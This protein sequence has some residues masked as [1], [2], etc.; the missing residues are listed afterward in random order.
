MTKCY[1]DICR[2]LLIQRMRKCL[3]DQMMNFVTKEV[4]DEVFIN[5]P[6]EDY[7][8]SDLVSC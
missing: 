7:N 1:R 4:V 5:L 6:S 2:Y 8:I 3:V